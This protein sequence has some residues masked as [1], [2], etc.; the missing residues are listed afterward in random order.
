MLLPHG[1]E[2]QGAEHSS[3]RL[4][5]YLQLCAEHNIQV[6]V[7]TTPAQIFH[8]LRRQM[9]RDLPHAADRHDPQEPAAASPGGLGPGRTGGRGSSSP[10]SGEIDPIDPAGVERVVFCSGKV[11][12]DLLEARRARG[13][14]NVRHH[15]HRA[16]LPLPQGAVRRRHRRLPAHR[17]DHLVPGRGPEPGRLGPDQTPLPRPD[18]GRQAASTMPAGPPPPHPPWVTTPPMWSSRSA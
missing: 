16:A 8:L 6:C 18:P 10:S 12:Y 15:P 2:G 1:L 3:A 7:P 11:Y 4:E 9:L 17:R 14:T 5:R 13:L